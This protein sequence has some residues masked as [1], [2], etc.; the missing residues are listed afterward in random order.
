LT[1]I[2][3]SR[4]LGADAARL[5]QE[6][7]ARRVGL[8]D[9]GSIP[10]RVI[11]ELET[12]LVGGEV[13]DLPQVVQTLALGLDPDELRLRTE[14]ARL[15]A[16]ALTETAT[17]SAGTTDS[18]LAARL[19]RAVRLAGAEDVLVLVGPAGQ[20]PGLPRTTPLDGPTNVMMQVEYKGHWVQVGRAL[21]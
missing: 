4:N 3:A 15:V 17:L 6:R 10:H 9:R 18:A 5:L 14:A 20:W 7:G 11:A 21:G 13:V 8:A 12:A 2:R 19:D 1:E 16:A